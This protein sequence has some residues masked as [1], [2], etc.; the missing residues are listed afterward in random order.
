MPTKYY[1]TSQSKR[2]VLRHFNTGKSRNF[3]RV[4]NTVSNELDSIA[5]LKTV[6]DDPNVSKNMEGLVDKAFEE[7]H[8][9]LREMTQVVFLNL[10]Y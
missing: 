8:V 7:L 3:G 4:I 6:L 1:G 10:Q 9:Q 2:S 5:N